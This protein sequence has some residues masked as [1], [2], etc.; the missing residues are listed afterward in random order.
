MALSN[1]NLTGHLLIAMPNMADP[2]FAKTVTLI[3][4]HNEDGAMG[5][6]IN[7]PTNVKLDE[8]YDNIQLPLNND[9]IKTQPVLFGGPVQPERGFVLHQS[10][11][12]AEN[13]WDSCIVVRDNIMLTTSKDI[14]AAIGTGDGPSKFHFS[15]GYAGWSPGQ[16]EAEILKNSWLSVEANNIDVL[17]KLLYDTA[18]ENMFD[19][20][21]KLLGIDPSMLSD[22]AG[23]A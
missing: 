16:L 3:C 21:M 1:I 12:A 20:S 4:T 18:H 2:F 5:I 22:V 9:A 23:H 15:L 17:N 14:L 19:A 10:I 8:L 11:H 13:N 6:I 7:Q